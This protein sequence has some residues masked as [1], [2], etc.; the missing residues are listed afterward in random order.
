MEEEN[1]IVCG[2]GIRSCCAN[3]PPIQMPLHR[4][5]Q[6]R[7]SRYSSHS[8]HHQHRH[9]LLQ[10][11]HINHRRHSRPTLALRHRTRTNPFHLHLSPLPELP[12]QQQLLLRHRL[13]LSRANHQRTVVVRFGY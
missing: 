10:R 13:Y 1:A 7:H 12:H 3:I 4:P 11:R 9:M 2:R 6:R 8:Q 5:L